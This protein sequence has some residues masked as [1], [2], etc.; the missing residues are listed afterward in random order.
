VLIC[1]IDIGLDG[2]FSV[3]DDAGEVIAVHDMPTL[4]A[5]SGNKRELDLH[6]LA[7]LL[8]SLAIDHAIVERVGA[9]PQQGVVS[10]FGFGQSFGATLGILACLNV[11]F[12][13]VP[14]ASWKRTLQVP[15]A[16][17]AARH[18]ASQLLPR[19]AHWWPRAKDHGRAEA[20]LLGYYGWR[21]LNHKGSR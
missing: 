17:D 18:R 13:L 19:A 14:P 3:I 15:K 2:A 6:A 8:R 11:P 10:S 4:A 20:S 9:R 16:K 1:G 7:A 12:S 5:R 21:Q